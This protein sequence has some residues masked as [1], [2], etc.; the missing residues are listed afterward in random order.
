[1]FIDTCLIAVVLVS[2]WKWPKWKALPILA[3]F[4]IVD[5]AYFGA[6]LLEGAVGRL[7]AFG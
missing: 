5:F 2:L 6:N 4:I 1:M 3:M 7:G